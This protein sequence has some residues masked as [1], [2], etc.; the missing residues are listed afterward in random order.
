MDAL[1]LRGFAGAVAEVL[2]LSGGERLVLI[3]HVAG[4]AGAFLGKVREG[5]FEAV[6]G[7]IRRVPV[8]GMF[9]FDTEQPDNGG[10]YCVKIVRLFELKAVNA[11]E[12]VSFGIDAAFD[13]G[14]CRLAFLSVSS[15]LSTP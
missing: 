13:E 14:V 1:A 12:Q 11:R 10:M 6:A 9:A 8:V 4:R 15:W 7:K 3:Q 5:R 2:I